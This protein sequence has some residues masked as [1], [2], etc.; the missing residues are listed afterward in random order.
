MLQFEI[1]AQCSVTKARVSKM[2]LLHGSVDT[3]IFMPVGTKGTMKG[4]TSSQLKDLNC[5]IILGNTYH[6]ALQ[7]VFYSFCNIRDKNS[8]IRSKDCIIL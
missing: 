7:P 8:L 1:I 2:H 4:I 6:L 5:Q 3:P